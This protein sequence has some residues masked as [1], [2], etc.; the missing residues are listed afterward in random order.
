MGVPQSA[1]S[2]VLP[3]L[4]KFPTSQTFSLGQIYRT[5]CPNSVDV[6][7]DRIV[8]LLDIVI[9]LDAWGPCTT[10]ACANS[11]FNCDGVINLLDIVLILSKYGTSG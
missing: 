5:T 1:M 3:N 6:N 11:D 8:N 4:N 7:G 10:V 9:L 2:F